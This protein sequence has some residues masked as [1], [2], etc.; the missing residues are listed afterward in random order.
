[1]RIASV[2]SLDFVKEQFKRPFPITDISLGNMLPASCE[3]SRAILNDV[4][5][6]RKGSQTVKPITLLVA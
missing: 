4:R 1:M 3:F 2:F 5:M 6:S